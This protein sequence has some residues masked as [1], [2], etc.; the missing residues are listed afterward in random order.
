MSVPFDDFRLGDARQ[1]LLKEDG[2]E[3]IDQAAEFD[4]SQFVLCGLP[5]RFD[6]F[7][8]LLVR[9]PTGQLFDLVQQV[10]LIIGLEQ[11]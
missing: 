8:S 5:T 6:L 1:V 3:C 4:F 10:L 2:F 9:L 11:R 7:Q